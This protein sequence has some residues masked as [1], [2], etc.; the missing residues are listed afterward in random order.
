MLNCGLSLDNIDTNRY[1]CA[2]RDPDQTRLSI[3]KTASQLFNKQG[4]KATSI[5]DITSE[6]PLTKGAIYKHFKDKSE[7]EKEALLFLCH[8]MMG[9]ISQR[10]REKGNAR[11]KLE[12]VIQYFEQY[13]IKAPF[14]Y[15]CPVMNAAIEAD[16]TNPSLKAVVINIFDE[17]HSSIVRI[18]NNGIKHGQIRADIEKDMIASFMINA[19]EGGV[20]MLKV[21][22]SPDHLNASLSYLKAELDRITVI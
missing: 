19:L 4:Y 14:A 6:L 15:G 8:K 3:L 20:M 9:S 17:F 13:A 12:A 16:D 21:T 7:L 18:L 11:A 22:D 10:I 2:V 5:S 1:L